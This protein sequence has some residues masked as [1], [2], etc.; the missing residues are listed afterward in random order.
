M[1]A[2]NDSGLPAPG[3]LP[4]PPVPPAERERVVDVLTQHYAND[5]VTETD[6]E[7]RLDRV[8]RAQTAAELAAVIADLPAFGAAPA[9]PAVAAPVQRVGA[10]LSGQE[11]RVTGLV[12]AELAL[13]ARLGYVELDL[14][15]ATFT[16]GV[17]HIDVRAFMG[18]VQIRFPAG[19]RVESDGHAFAGFFSLKGA[20][21]EAPGG[22][23]S[24]VRVT[25]RATFGFAECVVSSGAGSRSALPP[26]IPDT[27]RE[28]RR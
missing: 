3:P 14:T 20:D 7:D 21:R 23:A 13:R 15:R 12:P 25:G 11:R 19:I 6:L 28:G 22:A 4:T 1:T 5:R 27:G 16:P 10:L 8:Y 26:R 9:P 24:V 17:T 2:P 18:Y